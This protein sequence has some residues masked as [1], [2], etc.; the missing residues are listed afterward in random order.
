MYTR[1]EVTDGKTI[2]NKDLYDNI[3]D[4]V[5]EA[6][7]GLK[8]L[9]PLLLN[10]DDLALYNTDP[11]YGDEAL[12]AIIN[13]RPILVKTPNSDGGTYTAVYSPVYMYQVPNNENNYLYLF[14]LRDEKQ[15]L[16]LSALGAGT[17]QLPV[18]GEL[19]MRLSE[20]YNYNPLETN[21]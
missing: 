21:A 11:I 14:Y 1:R 5:E 8:G 20:T 13:G 9:K 19:K 18:Y 4:G 17:I 7:D 3:Q 6:L 2:M 15:T 10:A 12:Q 16:D